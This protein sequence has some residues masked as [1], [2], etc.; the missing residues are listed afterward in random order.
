MNK[1][2][3]IV[4]VI[5]IVLGIWFS[6]R[7]KKGEE[8]IINSTNQEPVSAVDSDEAKKTMTAILHTNQGD[9]GAEYSGQL[10]KIS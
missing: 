1:Y 9:I 5:I 7:E 3:S 8:N 2:I 4:I 6:M 10:C